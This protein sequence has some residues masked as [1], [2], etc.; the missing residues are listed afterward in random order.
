M[1]KYTKVRGMHD[2]LP[3]EISKWQF[4]EKILTEIACLYGY[5]EIRPPLV[6]SRT[7]FERSI[8][9]ES[10]IVSKEIYAFKDRKGRDIAL[11]PEGTASVVRAF[12]E[13]NMGTEKRI[14]R[15][16]YYGPMFRY[17]RPQKDR[18]RQFYQFGVELLGGKHPFFD[19]EVVVMLHTIAKKLKI[20]NYYFLVNTLG[21]LQC[22]TKFSNIIK[23]YFS[24]KL[25]H[26]CNDC[27]QRIISS[28]LRILDCKNPQC[29]QYVSDAPV[30]VDLLCYDC[31]NHFKRFEEYINAHSVPYKVDSH[32][33]RGLDYYTKTV[34]ELYVDQDENAIA[35]GGRYDTLVK[36]L[37][38]HDIP[39]VGFAI[40]MER[41]IPLVKYEGP[42][43]NFFYLACI[44]EEV[45]L[46]GAMIIN[47]MR[48]KGLAVETDYEQTSLRSHLK[49]AN[50]T[51][52]RWCI[53]IG[54]EEIK[55]KEFI[56]RDMI[57]GEQIT[58]PLDNHINKIQELLQ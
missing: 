6:E 13:S 30:I 29:K 42:E 38:G 4:I 25:T 57:S 54:E 1:G 58:I 17:D 27:Q 56:V 8:G 18:Y 26:L 49:T 51:G 7:L 22:K 50:K 47:E 33:V 32:L 46:K 41:L 24:E 39:A 10:D 20:E 3:E 52:A 21:C 53:I 45:K 43:K 9:S 34:F 11:R 35:A 15:L 40:G 12:I 2:I 44:G 31:Q 37:G 14:F 28:P 55:K 23:S 19:G 5:K 48:S 36:Q 16:Y